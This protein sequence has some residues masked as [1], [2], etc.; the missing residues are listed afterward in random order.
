[1]FKCFDVI[2]L[3]KP[4]TFQGIQYDIGREGCIVEE[5]GDGYFEIEFDNPDKI[6]THAIHQDN[7]ELA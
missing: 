1:M 7:F 4:L 2:K 6:D 5:F 3:T